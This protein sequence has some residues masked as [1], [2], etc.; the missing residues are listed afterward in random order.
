[1]EVSPASI[2]GGDTIAEA[3][4]IFS[5]IIQ[6]NGTPE[7]EAVVLA[8]SAIALQVTGVYTNYADAFAA[9]KESLQSGKAYQCLQKLIALQ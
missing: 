1:M 5:N 2:K 6:G 7:Q 9:A 3:A 8:N 4:K